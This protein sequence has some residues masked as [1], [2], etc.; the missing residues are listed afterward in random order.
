MRP[1]PSAP[2][3]LA[4]VC[5]SGCAEQVDCDAAQ[6]IEILVTEFDQYWGRD[7]E[8]Y[9][10]IS[11]GEVSQVT[12]DDGTELEITIR[13]RPLP[14]A[15]RAYVKLEFRSCC[16]FNYPAI[17]LVVWAV[18]AQDNLRAV[19]RVM[20][21][22]SDFLSMDGA[23]I[24]YRAKDSGQAYEDCG[25]TFVERPLVVEWAGLSQE[26]PTHCRVTVGEL[27]INH[28]ETYSTDAA[29]LTCYDQPTT[30]S[31]GAIYDLAVEM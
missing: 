31:A 26:V 21:N 12:F 27:E 22:G 11:G 23:D 20:W 13:S 14:A 8:G 17:R 2:I 6:P 15:E 5:G 9:A 30:M 7:V 28:R 29:T 25:A 4:L 10:R 18:D 19:E 16:A 1:G 24:S 3:I